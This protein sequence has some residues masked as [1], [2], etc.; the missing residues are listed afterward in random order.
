MT[1]Q[2]QLSYIPKFEPFNRV[3]SSEFLKLQESRTQ[4]FYIAMHRRSHAL[5]EAGV[6]QSGRPGIWA[7]LPGV[8]GAASRGSHHCGGRHQ[9]PFFVS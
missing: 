8:C 5:N 3:Y 2:P 1:N 7:S 4:G 9:N 6:S